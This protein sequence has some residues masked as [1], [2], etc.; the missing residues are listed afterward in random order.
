MEWCLD[1]GQRRDTLQARARVV[2]VAVREAE[3][4][5]DEAGV[6]GLQAHGEEGNRFAQHV[7]RHRCLEELARR[8]LPPALKT[9][10]MAFVAL[11]RFGGQE[12]G[13]CIETLGF[14]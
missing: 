4:Q 1:A 3:A 9:T 10:S 6:S 8:L 12:L 13:E 2:G 5:V 7:R 11:P 14:Y